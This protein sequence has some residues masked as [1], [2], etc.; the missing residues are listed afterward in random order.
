MAPSVTLMRKIFEKALTIGF[1]TSAAKPHKAKQDV[2]RING[3]TKLIPSRENNELLFMCIVKSWLIFY[4][5]LFISRYGAMALVSSRKV[6]SPFL[7]SWRVTKD[8]GE[9]GVT[10]G[11]V[12]AASITSHTFVSGCSPVARTNC[13][14]SHPLTGIMASSDS[15]L[16]MTEATWCFFRLTTR[17]VM[18]V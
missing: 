6:N 17:R 14:L 18:V 15:P 8:F 4:F 11:T 2:I 9:A 3:N 12:A 5:F 10:T 1:V 13:R 16:L 7:N